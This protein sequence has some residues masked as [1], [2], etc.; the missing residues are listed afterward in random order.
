MARKPS[1][2]SATPPTG[3]AGASSGGSSGP[4]GSPRERIIAALFEL[5]AERSLERIT[6]ADIARA[7]EVP[8]AD[9]RGE[10][11]STVGILAAHMKGLDRAVLAA[12]DTDMLEESPRERLFDVLMRRLELLTPHKAAVRSLMRSVRRDPPLALALNC[13][14]TR[15][16]QWMLT[17]AGIDAAG[18]RGMVRAQGLALLMAR[19]LQVWVED[20]D[21]GL[22][23]TMAALDRELGRGQRWSGFL[24]DLCRLLPSRLPGFRRRSR[25]DRGF[26]D[27]RGERAYPI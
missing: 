25:R 16:Q 21:P 26:D 19:V 27:D 12:D 22:A 14:A 10:F 7:A 9:L 4:T 11:D 13:L 6:F 17:A 8:L 20:D 24:D 5:L 15:S 2:N 1:Q 18:P 3:N 23:R